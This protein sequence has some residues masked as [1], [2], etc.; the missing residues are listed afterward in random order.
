MAAR[1]LTPCCWRLCNERRL[2][3]PSPWRPGHSAGCASWAANRPERREPNC[4]PDG[5]QRELAGTARSAPRPAQTA[6]AKPGI[7]LGRPRTAC[8]RRG[9]RLRK[10]AGRSRQRG[11]LSMRPLRP[12]VAT[13][14]RQQPPTA[15]AAPTMPSQRACRLAP[16]HATTAY[17]RVDGERH[18]WTRVTALR[19]C[20][21]RVAEL[22]TARVKSY[23]LAAR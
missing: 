7:D 22:C 17:R 13:C 9:A 5:C 19:F 18:H 21:V 20:W 1:C 11:N 12:D 6:S 8:R 14:R 23:R 10:R 15:R 2:P 16:A 4:P 3:W